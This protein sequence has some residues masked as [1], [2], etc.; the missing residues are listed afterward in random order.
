MSE[1]PEVDIYEFRP[2]IRR[3]CRKAMIWGV[4]VVVVLGAVAWL[5]RTPS[6]A[7]LGRAFGVLLA[8]SLLFWVS[9]AKIWWTAGEPAVLMDEE[10]LHYQPLHGFRRRSIAFETVVA[11]APRPG[12]QSLRFVHEWRPGAAREFFLNLGVV[13]GR[14][15]FLDRLGERLGAVGVNE[16]PGARHTWQ[17]PGWSESV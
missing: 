17:R 4:G 16:V 13:G 5:F 14:N 7:P 10:A 8:Y 15:E 6:S 11:C 9:L 1:I 12:T 2:W 3:A